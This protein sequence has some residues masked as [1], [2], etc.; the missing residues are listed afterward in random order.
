[1]NNI[2]KGI[3]IIST[4][5]C[6]VIVIIGIVRVLIMWNSLP[7]Q[8]GVHFA[9][10]GTFDVIVNKDKWLYLF[11][12]YY[13]SLIIILLSELFIFALDRVKIGLKVNKNNEDKIKLLS[14]IFIDIFFKFGW[15]FFLSIIW[16][17]CVIR[18][19][20][21]N[22]IIPKIILIIQFITIIILIISITIIR[23]LN[24]LKK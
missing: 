14:E 7:N 8:I 11:Y 12:P 21:L 24:K 5:I 10:D 15:I 18:Q 17:D 9:G 6:L 23:L 19:H 20:Y 13:V 3:H 4:V 16:G 1:M 2:R 22:T